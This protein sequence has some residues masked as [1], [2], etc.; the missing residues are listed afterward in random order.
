MQ[1]HHCTCGDILYWQRRS[2]K[3][4]TASRLRPVALE[5]HHAKYL[6]IISTMD[7]ICHTLDWRLRRQGICNTTM[8]LMEGK[9]RCVI[10]NMTQL[11]Y[12]IY[13]I[14]TTRN[15]L[16]RHSIDIIAQQ[17][18]TTR[19]QK[20]YTYMAINNN[21]GTRKTTTTS[22]HPSDTK[23]TTKKMAIERQQSNNGARQ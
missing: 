2:A 3:V 21:N 22:G 9:L 10:K 11:L 7:R 1:Q 13:R 16:R 20:H 15:Q 6:C 5:W 14:S 8:A 23:N 17:L 19:Q 4:S 12:G 18:T